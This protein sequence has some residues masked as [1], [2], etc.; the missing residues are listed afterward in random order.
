[1]GRLI[2]IGTGVFATSDV[3]FCG[4]LATSQGLDHCDIETSR[5]VGTLIYL[6]V[7]GKVVFDVNATISELLSA[8]G[9]NE[10]CSMFPTRCDVSHPRIVTCSWLPGWNG[11]KS[12]PLVEVET[13]II[14]AMG[15]D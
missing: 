5:G 12:A 9:E 8:E 6:T 7:M 3:L 4:K 13:V 15:S 14:V 1:M 2:D 10:V 11:V